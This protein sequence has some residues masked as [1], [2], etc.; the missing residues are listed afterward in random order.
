MK[1]IVE[2]AVDQRIQPLVKMLGT[3]QKFLMEQ[4]DGG[5]TLNEIVGRI[6][7]ILG[8]V[9]VAGYFMGRNRKARS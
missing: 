6:G 1:K 3:Q 2:D 5:P 8:I 9:G 7:W 4:R